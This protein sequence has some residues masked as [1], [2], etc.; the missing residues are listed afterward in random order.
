MAE[1]RPIAPAFVVPGP[2]GVAVR[3]RLK[4]LTPADEQALRL[5]GAHLGA[6]ASRDL[7]ARCADGLERSSHTWAARK[8][9]LT[10]QSSARWAGAITKASSD[11]LVQ[12]P[13]S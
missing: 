12:D 2:S 1:P 7:K 6:P 9:E 5:V 11:L 8:R 3:D 4:H 13:S 10:V